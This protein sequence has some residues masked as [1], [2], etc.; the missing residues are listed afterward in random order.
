M[1]WLD[2]IVDAVSGLFGS[3]GG[4]AATQG[5]SEAASTAGGMG[6]GDI[7]NYAAGIPEAG[8]GVYSYIS[9]ESDYFTQLGGLGQQAG[10]GYYAQ[11]PALADWTSYGA[12]AA[13]AGTSGTL[14][15]AFSS[16]LDSAGNAAKGAAQWAEKNPN[17]TKMGLGAGMAGGSMLYNRLNQ[18]KM[19]SMNFPAPN[20]GAPAPLVPDYTPPPGTQASPLLRGA[21]PQVNDKS[22]LSKKSGGMAAF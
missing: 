21:T 5:A 20:A 4:E 6:V 9:P 1:G 15:S 2:S 12:P 10:N 14:G 7:A 13:A 3:G 17:L 8:S 22:G 16:G 18:P 19:P 11:A